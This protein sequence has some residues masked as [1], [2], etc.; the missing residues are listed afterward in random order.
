MRIG[1][2]ENVAHRIARLCCLMAC[3]GAV[4]YCVIFLFGPT[5]TTCSVPT[6][7]PDQP[8]ATFGP[9]SCR[10]ATFFE[11]NG[12][13]PFAAEQLVRPLFFFTLWTVA[14]FIAL[15]GV[16]IRARG[17]LLGIGLVAIGLLIDAS[18][19][20]SMGGGFVFALLC[21][22]LLA[23]ALVATLAMRRQESLPVRL[24]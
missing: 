10:S 17:H 6:I 3:A 15:L 16:A 4:T 18:S 24:S 13:G 1:Y 19:I 20:I 22:P 23:V 21:V 7:G 2:V 14:P 12:S 8:A 11:V 9:G 5:Y